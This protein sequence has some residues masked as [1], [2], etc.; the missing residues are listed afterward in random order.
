MLPHR[1]K[2][3]LRV[4]AA[5]LTAWLLLAGF[6][7]LAKAGRLPDGA[8]TA[9]VAP[10]APAGE[11]AVETQPDGSLVLTL[12]TQAFTIQEADPAGVIADANCQ[13]LSAPGYSVAAAPG[14]PALP[15]K[16]AL[17][18][19]PGLGEPRLEILQAVSETLP[20]KY[21][22]CAVSDAVSERH[23]NGLAAFAGYRYF[24]DAAL[25]GRDAFTGGP[26]ALL[27]P[28]AMIRSQRVAQVSFRPFAYNPVSG[29]VRIYR[30]LRVRLAWPASSL[31]P[32]ADAGE[33]RLILE[34]QPF[35][36]S[37]RQTL[38]NYD[39]ARAWRHAPAPVQA[40]SRAADATLS[41]S[42][43]AY[44]VVVDQTGLHRITYA[45]LAAAGALATELDSLDPL[46][47]DL[48]GSLPTP[49]W[50]SGED[51]GRFDPGDAIWFYGVKSSTRWTA[52][53]VYRL[54]WGGA[55]GARM[56]AQAVTP[57]LSLPV[58]Q[59]Y[60][61]TLRVE[62][63]NAQYQ[64]NAP[65]IVDGDRFYWQLLSASGHTPKQYGITFT[66]SHVYTAPFQATLGG[67]LKS[68]AA[69]PAHLTRIFLNAPDRLV[70]EKQWPS[71]SEYVFSQ[72]IPGAWLN[73][74]LN[75]I[76]ITLP[77]TLPCAINCMEQFLLNWFDVTY[78]RQY[79]AVNNALSFGGAAGDWAF[80]VSGFTTSTVTLLDVTDPHTPARLTGAAALP[81][82]AGY[83]LDF[84]R[85]AATNRRYLA[86][87]DGLAH[88]PK[89]LLP[90][91]P[92]AGLRSPANAADYLIL[93]YGPFITATQPLAAARAAQG[94]TVKTVDVQDIYDEFNDGNL[95]PQAI[96][97]F[98]KFAYANWSDPKPAYVL[99]VGD[100]TVDPLGNFGLVEPEFVPPYLDDV[101]LWVGETATDNRFAMVSG[102]D[103]LPDLFVGRFPARSAAD[104]T[105]MVSKTLAYE[106]T[107]AP[108]DW[109]RK[110][111]FIADAPDSGGDFHAYSDAIA[112]N[113]V[114][115]PYVVDKIHMPSMPWNQQPITYRYAITT[116]LNEGRLMVSYIGHAGYQSWS[117]KR[118]LDIARLKTVNNG[119]RLPFVT[120]MTCSEGYFI[121][122][123]LVNPREPLG[124]SDLS[125]M[126]ESFIRKT[127]G[128]AIA[129]FSPTG[130]GVAHGHDYLERGLYLALFHDYV[131]Q[132]GPAVNQA[133][134][135]LYAKT[136]GYLDLVET[137]MLF[138][139]PAVRLPIARPAMRFAKQAVAPMPG[140]DP[141]LVRFRLEFENLGDGAAYSLAISDL[142]PAW[143]VTGTFT[144]QLSAG[145]LALRSGPAFVF[146]V[147]D[148]PPGGGGAI[149]L[150]LRASPS[151]WGDFTNQ[152]TLSAVG[153]KTPQHLA[154]AVARFYNV[155]L[156]IIKK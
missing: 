34:P 32:S 94:Y 71:G 53:N 23:A 55:P 70:V 130:F 84:E 88:R 86:V 150:T 21:H 138:G 13:E 44:Q 151:A 67:D 117:G 154:E 59:S 115:T 27:N 91:R 143:A 33:G 3:S 97:D 123:A 10:R 79:I 90:A 110:F 40:G 135:Y 101:D 116:G 105:V 66:L 16:G 8:G 54:T 76:T 113:Y 14:A 124:Y 87:A 153:D 37:L 120:P 46:S 155:L 122:P 73:D 64:S 60:S 80:Q 121:N 106:Q 85:S 129:T 103:K 68:F 47:F 11:V 152:A 1:I 102:D 69:T 20:G 6:S 52:E 133:K 74:G 26:A 63:G 45:D 58:A 145:N 77:M 28:P 82:G 98:L 72:T 65:S 12:D 112:D 140:D 107:P 125:A 118:L 109:T 56:T 51:D 24:E 39:Q 4:C 131:D 96:A 15:V 61:E 146:D 149:T 99:L 156:P 142:L 36:D 50:V 89:R 25:Y 49:V 5:I 141:G 119:L 100:G 42:L 30:R 17:V 22:L 83:R 108:G 35:E 127:N 31:P 2:T 48:R 43:P 75:N 147:T 95:N 136:G 137:Y 19:I 41:S 139:D 111:M 81:A 78:A 92:A 134:I 93:S 29:E 148:L 126:A 57:T 9:V 132:L 62:R 104:V 18:G 144:A 128:G 38:L 114:P 7:A